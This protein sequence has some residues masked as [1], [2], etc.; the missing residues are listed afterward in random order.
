M[1]V[2]LL[3]AKLW[4]LHAN[5]AISFLRSILL[6]KI[7]GEIMDK[8]TSWG[9]GVEDDQSEVGKVPCCPLLIWEALASVWAG[10]ADFSFLGSHL[11][12]FGLSGE[13]KLCAGSACLPWLMLAEPSVIALCYFTSMLSSHVA[14]LLPRNEEEQSRASS[15]YDC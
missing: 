15:F 7:W 13:N 3:Q 5:K 12:V 6:H 10:L 14:L 4:P 1:K 9:E 11:N 8:N 2:S